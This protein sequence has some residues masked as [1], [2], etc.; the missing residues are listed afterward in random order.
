MP[1]DK[2]QVYKSADLLSSKWP[3]GT[4]TQLYIYPPGADYARRDFLFRISTAIVEKD[5]SAF[6]SLPGFTRH[7]MILEGELTIRHAGQYEKRLKPFGQDAFDG[8]WETSASGQVIDFNLMCASQAEGKLHHHA[9]AEDQRLAPDFDGFALIYVYQGCIL[10]NEIQSAGEKDVVVI[11]P[12]SRVSIQ[13]QKATEL[14]V[15]EVRLRD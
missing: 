5:E 6:T 13:A 4:T 12:E 2:I 9:L 8:G 11:R 3:G 1:R 15:A 14:I 10:V 7:L